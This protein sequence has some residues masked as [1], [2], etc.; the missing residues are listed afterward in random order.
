MPWSESLYW[1]LVYSALVSLVVLAFGSGAVLLCRQPARRLRIIEL[2]LA[3]CLIA[4]LLGMIPGYPQLAIVW[5]HAAP[6]Q[7][8][9]N[10][11]AALRLGRQ[12]C[13]WSPPIPMFASHRSAA[14]DLPSRADC[15]T[16]RDAGPCLGCRFMARR[17]VLAG[18]G[19]RDRVVAGGDGRAG[20][21]HLD[22]T[23]RAA[24]LPAI[25]GGDCRP[26]QC[27][28]ATVGEPS[29]EAAVCLGRSGGSTAAATC[30]VA[31]GGDRA[32]REPVRR[33]ASGPLGAGP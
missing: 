3:G 11:D 17:A 4:P 29:G 21:D 33:R 7:R 20:A 26:A 14:V 25:A 24:A 2:S 30:G 8:A 22:G 19:D 28:G 32:A 27:S 12:S 31:S 1:W 23:R 6:P 18:R 9:S 5:R 10:F 15:R 13:R 16:D